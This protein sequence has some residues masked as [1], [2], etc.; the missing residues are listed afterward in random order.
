MGHKSFLSYMGELGLRGVTEYDYKDKSVNIN[1]EIERMLERSLMMYQWHNLPETIPQ[2]QLEL[3][4]QS[5][6]YAIIGEINGG[7]YACYGGLGGL[8]DEYNRPTK[9]IVSI[10][11]FNFNAEWEID[12]ECIVIKNDTLLQGMLPLYSKYTTILNEIDITLIMALVNMRV[13]AY[14]SASDDKSIESAKEFLRKLKEGELGVI[15]DS[16]MFDSL[17]IN[18]VSYNQDIYKLREVSQYIRGQLF[19]EIGLATNYNLKKERITQAE[20]ELNTDNLY[21]FIDNMYSERLE[22]IKRVN[23]FFGSDWGVEFNSSWDYRVYN[24]EPIT[25]KPDLDD[26][27]GVQ[28]DLTGDIENNTLNENQE[29]LEGVQDVLGG[30][31]DNVILDDNNGIDSDN[32]DNNIGETVTG[33]DNGVDVSM[34]DNEKETVS[35]DSFDNS[36]ISDYDNDNINSDTDTVIPDNKEP[37]LEDNRAE[38]PDEV[39]IDVENGIIDLAEKIVEVRE[40]IEYDTVEKS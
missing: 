7:I 6:G 15:A 21:P 3:I 40:E 4:L 5:Q 8:L 36:D 16:K 39:L 29:D 18:E 17:K 22:G 37:D 35:V 2:R 27:G 38:Y 31:S 13:Q 24:G 26:L 20:I 1:L 12:K 10:P 23:D 19:N 30:D 14:I 11:Y 9:A 28:E 32:I 34:A 33:D 25:T